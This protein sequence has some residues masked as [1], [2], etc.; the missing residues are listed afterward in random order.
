MAF[1]EVSVVQVKEALRRWLSGDG[2]RPIARGVGIDRKTAR[3]YITAAVELGVDRDGGI[4][5]LTDELIGLVLERV[6][7]CRPDGHGDAW[8]VLLAEEDRIKAWVKEDLTVVKIG[9]LL[10]RRGVVVPH[11]TLARF[12]VERCG[13]GRRSITVRVDD[14]PPGIELQVDFG[15]LGLVPDGEK[16]RVCQA[17]IFTACFSRHQFV[18]PTFTQTTADVIAGFEAAWFYFGGVFPVV[19]PDNMASI[20]AKAENTAPRFN[21]VFFEYA[22]SRG[23]AIDAARVA[24]P[25][26]KPRVERTVPYV[27]NNFFAGETFVD[28]ADCRA[29][30]ERWC[31]ETAGMR[32]H[33]T[34]QCRPIESFRTEELALLVCLPG[35]PFD[36]PSWSEPKV[37]RD[38]HVEV[39]KAIYSVPHRLIGQ[40][41]TA[42]RDSTTVK[43]YFRGELVKVHA[44][45]APGQRSTDPADLPTGTEIYATR[46]VDRL[47]RMAAD[48]GDAIG[49]YAAALLDTPLPW[50]KMRQVYRLLGL[51]KKWGA[52]RVEQA[53]RRALDAEAVDVNLVARMLERAR[54]D[55]EPDARPE[56]VVIQ[57]RFARDPSEFA[58]TTEASR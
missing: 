5:Q 7:P 1:R 48:H 15:R 19:I 34:T 52:P 17:L 28:L 49:I 39:D 18:W 13:A 47:R 14:P 24:T 10:G 2:E 36:V 55:L 58:T 35:A 12:A 9:V 45:R 50:T 26:D 57:G 30:A 42:R 27:R 3:R 41:L 53:C 40:R 6:R 43:L 46:D 32:I 8:R 22:Q 51:V 37:H 11:R 56:P 29:R 54:E 33:G 31:T 16:R 4:E 21:D 25:T 23:F 44:R 20:V 38:F